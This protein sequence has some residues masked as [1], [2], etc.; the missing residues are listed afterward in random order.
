MK[1]SLETRRDFFKKNAKLLSVLALAATPFVSI[2]AS[3]L[4]A[5]DCGGNCEGLCSKGCQHSCRTMCGDSCTNQCAQRCG[6]TCAS[7]CG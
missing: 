1:D 6:F 4:H 3:V 5:K 7:E 2:S